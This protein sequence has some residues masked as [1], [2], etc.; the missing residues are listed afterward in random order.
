MD[1]NKSEVESYMCEVGLVLNEISFML[2]HIRNYSKPKKVATPLAQFR[3]ESYKLA[4]PYGTVLIISPWN[5]PFMLS[6]EPLVD[7]LSA[8]NSIILKPSEYSP[9]VSNVLEKL[10]NQ[11]FFAI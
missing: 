5:Y 8:G 9:N 4:C 6:V 2:K 10:I 3:A 1:L 7:A 11:T